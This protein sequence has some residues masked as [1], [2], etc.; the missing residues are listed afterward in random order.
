MLKPVVFAF[1]FAVVGGICNNAVAQKP[2]FDCTKA[3]YEHEKA[4]CSSSKLAA[5]DLNL[6]EQ[7]KSAQATAADPA[8]LKS[9]QVAWIKETRKCGADVACLERAY[10]QRIAELTPVPTSSPVAAVPVQQASTSMAAASSAAPSP[11]ASE[12]TQAASKPDE[13]KPAEQVANT[14]KASPKEDKAEA[15]W[16]STYLRIGGITVAVIACIV[17]AYWMIRKLITGAKNDQSPI[18]KR[19]WFWVIVFSTILSIIFI[20]TSSIYGNPQ[21]KLK[22]N[23]PAEVAREVGIAGVA[24]CFAVG[25]ATSALYANN[26]NLASQHSLVKQNEI[27]VNFFGSARKSLIKENPAIDQAFD[28]LLKQNTEYIR[29]IVASSGSQSLVKEISSCEAKV[30]RPD[31]CKPAR[32]D[33]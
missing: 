24:K 8:K 5:L 31:S 6:S 25:L 2:S 22:L 21:R 30:F 29:R 14:P 4:I 27:L 3:Q 18:Y 12:S 19:W 33:C 23:D 7:Y 16:E 15:I 13:V 9:D 20:I 1:M 32:G 10:T 11:V 26:K 17:L 28:S